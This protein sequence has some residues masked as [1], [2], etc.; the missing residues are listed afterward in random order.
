MATVRILLLFVLIQASHGLRLGGLVALGGG[1]SLTL[2][3]PKP[4]TLVLPLGIA[5]PL[6]LASLGA[7]VI[8]QVSGFLML[9]H[10]TVGFVS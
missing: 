9:V 10:S 8:N 6:Q 1:S 4:G 5:A 2:T 3:F 7:G